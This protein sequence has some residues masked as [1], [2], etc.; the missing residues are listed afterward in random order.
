LLAYALGWSLHEIDG[1]L[2]LSLLLGDE[3]SSTVVLA[4][5]PALEAELRQFV[6]LSKDSYRPVQEWLRNVRLDDCKVLGTST[7]DFHEAVTEA[8]GHQGD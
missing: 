5:T 1:R 2:A 4:L 8:G 7:N 6:P 3:D